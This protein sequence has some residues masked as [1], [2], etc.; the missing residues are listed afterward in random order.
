MNVMYSALLLMR[1]VPVETQRHFY[2]LASDVASSPAVQTQ[3]YS[4]P[5]F[6]HLLRGL[7]LPGAS[8]GEGQVNMVCAPAVYD[9]SFLPALSHGVGSISAAPIFCCKCSQVVA[10]HHQDQ[11]GSHGL[12]DADVMALVGDGGNAGMP[13]HI[14]KQ[15]G[16]MAV[17]LTVCNYLLYTA[18]QYLHDA[19]CDV[20]HTAWVHFTS[21]LVPSAVESS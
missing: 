11:D 14:V 3:V 15:V 10:P 12:R 17:V 13:G 19:I 6:M 8:S 7:Q 9:E 20:V 16:L 2:A 5:S 21:L 1:G 4:H 18:P